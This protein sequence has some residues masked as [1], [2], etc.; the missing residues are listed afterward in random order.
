M[1][2]RIIGS[3]KTIKAIDKAMEDCYYAQKAYLADALKY[4]KDLHDKDSYRKVQE[5]NAKWH[6]ALCHLFEVMENLETCAIDA[7]VLTAPKVK[8]PTESEPYPP[9]YQHDC[10]ACTYLGQV[11][12]YD[13]Y[14]CPQGKVPTVIARFGDEGGDYISEMNS[15][16]PCL[17]TAQMLAIEKGLIK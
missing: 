3:N 5:S 13:L 2:Q 12:E 11:E 15:D 10:T 17:Q 9:R 16:M 8:T 7:P 1:G 6:V 4:A 14:Y